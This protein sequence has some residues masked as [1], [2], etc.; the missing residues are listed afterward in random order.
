MFTKVLIFKKKSVHHLDLNP[1]LLNPSQLH[2]RWAV[3]FDRM[4]LKFS[5]LLCLQATVERK[6]IIAFTR[7]DK[8]EEE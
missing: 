2:Y 3:V 7:S 4:L 1:Q 5:P 8:L 6:L